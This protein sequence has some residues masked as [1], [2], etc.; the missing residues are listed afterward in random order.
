MRKSLCFLAAL[1]G[2]A[3]AGCS[4]GISARISEKSAMYEQ[5]RPEIQQKLRDGVVEPGYTADMVYVALGAPNRT[6]V[7]QTP[8]GAVGFWIYTNLFPEGFVPAEPAA[9]AKNAGTAPATGAKSGEG[10]AY[11]G[12]S[13]LGPSHGKS[14]WAFDR[15]GQ[16][17]Y[18]ASFSDR[19]PGMEPLDIPDMESAKLYVMFFEGRVVKISLQRG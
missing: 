1:L 12:E 4:N 15:A 19:D 5:L 10:W 2:L 17:P 9:T 18:V 7:R 11:S 8:H 13:V 6:E 14:Y 3:L 16:K